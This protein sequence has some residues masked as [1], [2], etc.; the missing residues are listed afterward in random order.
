[1]KKKAILA[2]LLSVAMCFTACDFEDLEESVDSTPVSQSAKNETTKESSSETTEESKDTKKDNKSDS[3][4]KGFSLS[5]DGASGTLNVTRARQKST[6]MGND[7]TWTIFVY[8]CGTDLESEDG[9]GAATDDLDQMLQAKG[10]DNVRFIVQTGGTSEWQN[11]VFSNKACER[12]LV[13]N[14][15]LELVDSVPLSNMGKSSTLSDFLTWGVQNYPADKMGVVF[16]NHGGGSITGAC[17]DELNE[18]DSL[19][20]LEINDALSKTYEKMS[21]RFEF[22][23]FDCCLM[24]SVESANVLATYAR[25]FFGS[26]EVEPG[27]GW[28]YTAIGDYL[29]QNSNA[30]GASLGKV[31]TDSFYSECEAIDQESECTFTIVDLDK[32]DEFSV[33]FNDYAKALYEA[34]ANDLAGIVRGAQGA[35]NF[36]GNNRSEGYTNMVDVGGIIEKCSAYAD[37][38]AA[39]K[40][41]KNCIVYNK[42]GDTHS[43][44]SG[45]SIYYPLEVQGS[46]EIEIFSGVCIS[47]YYLSLV[48][49]VARGY[50]DNG[51]TNDM[52]FDDDGD[53]FSDNG[54]ND[55]FDD[56]YFDYDYEEEGE[57]SLI[58]FTQ[59]PATDQDGFGFVLSQKS[60]EYTASVVAYVFLEVDDE[61]LVCLGETDDII[62]DWNTGAFRDN[63]DGYWLSLPS[64][65]LLTT[66]VA[67]YG[68]DYT[69]YTCPILLN[70]TETNLRVRQYYDYSVVVEGV[71]DGIGEGGCAGREI[72][73]LKK[74]DKIVPIYYLDDESEIEG[75]SYTWKKNDNLDYAY[76]PAGDYYYGFEINDVY[77]DYY[78]TDCEIFTIDKKGDIYFG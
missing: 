76:L 68:D 32:F 34:S 7:G 71:W 10:S 1:M 64:G 69:V 15:D 19:S 78:I 8:L 30:D 67:D 57:S 31:V 58:T 26:E 37:G 45:L 27:S 42:N 52:F 49:M 16:W 14:Q 55:Y 13:Q 35:D 36:G 21:D 53:W 25:Y 41:L 22:I 18:D 46:K 47:P 60:L 44:A 56:S 63:F 50:S 6:P 23:G 62:G 9:Y 59:K 75:D 54:S 74:G 12:Y 43:G 40:A 70:G 72:K 29:A 11:N 24:G 51:Y 20:L 5:V 33:A 28:N 48:D 38:S 4:T 2:L 3:D 17:F 65:D 66:Y 39:L 73:P 77:G 61:T